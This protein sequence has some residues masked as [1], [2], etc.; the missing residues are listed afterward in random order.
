[1]G[2]TVR[3]RPDSRPQEIKAWVSIAV[4]GDRTREVVR[5]LLGEPALTSL[6][7]TNGRWDL[8]AE[9]HAA[10][11]AELAEVLERVRKRPKWGTQGTTRRTISPAAFC[12]APLLHID[13]RRRESKLATAR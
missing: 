7:D 12:L 3:L 1:M 13:F 10:S 6:H 11:I 8:L 9:V 2:Y 5:S 4:A